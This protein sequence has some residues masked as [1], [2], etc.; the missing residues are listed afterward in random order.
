MHGVWRDGN[1]FELLAESSRF[2][3]AMFTAIEEAHRSILIELYLMES[4]HLATALIEAL[5][6]AAQRGVAVALM[7]DAYGAMGLS[8]E[9]RRRLE[10]AGVALRLFNPLGMRSLT[11]NLMRDHRKLVVV[12]G[13]VAFT[14]ASARSMSSSR[15][16]TRWRCAS[17]V[18]WWPTGCGC[19]RDCGIR[20]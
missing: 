5:C 4:G 7:L 8:G 6:R 20:R 3:P 9:D 17:K 16:G 10:Q 14:G 11:R 18:P 19:S 13:S 2:L 1:R 12:D 15:P